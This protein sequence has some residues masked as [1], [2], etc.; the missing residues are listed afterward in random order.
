M[1]KRLEGEVWDVERC[2]GCGACV[3]SCSKRVLNF[4]PDGEHPSKKTI[5]KTVGRTNSKLD[6]CYFCEM[7]GETLCELSCPRLV[8]DW[9]D[10]P[11]MKKLLV[12]TLGKKKSGN[13]NEIIGN[14][15]IGAMQAKMID[16]AIIS[17]IDRWTLI[18]H[19]TVATSISDIVESAGN[20][21]IWSPTL[22]SLKDAVYQMGL[23]NLAVVGTPC[24]MQ[25][26]DCMGKTNSKALRYIS[27]RL[28]LKVGLFCS[29]VY[30]QEALVT[31]A[32]ILKIPP[33]KIQS[34]SVSQKDN[35]LR[36]VT[37]EGKKRTMKLSELTKQIRPGCGRCY[38]LLSE[39]ADI[40]I[41]P[42]GAQ[43]GYSVAILRTPAG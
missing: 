34:I 32:E 2:A 7:E 18:P 11:V 1:S 26:L 10:G 39:A 36:I 30:T 13:P 19:P 43:D 5:W 28:K 38:D 24:M 41:G 23:K 29:G 31:I 42:I 9:P 6:V 35:L 20:Q 16:G 15:L 22:E 14:L 3:L 27:D 4:S 21:Y 37:H 25:A 12:S 33:F 8:E 17:D 40:S